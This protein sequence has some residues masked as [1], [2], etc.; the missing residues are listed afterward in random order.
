MNNKGEHMKDKQFYFLLG[1][2][3]AF[4]LAMVI[5]CSFTPLEAGGSELGGSEWNPMYVKIVD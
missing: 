4:M 5:S 2:I 1:F 3:T